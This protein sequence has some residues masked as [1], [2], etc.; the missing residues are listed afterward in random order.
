LSGAVSGQSERPLH[1]LL[2]PIMVVLGIT[3]VFAHAFR[4]S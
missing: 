1:D 2:L 3:N 4:L